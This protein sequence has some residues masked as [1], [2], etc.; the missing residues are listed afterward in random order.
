[1]HSHPILEV[2][3][4]RWMGDGRSR[5]NCKVVKVPQG[6]VL[7]IVLRKLKGLERTKLKKIKGAKNE[8]AGKYKGRKEWVVIGQGGDGESENASRSFP[9]G[10]M[11]KTLSFQCRKPKVPQPETKDPYAATK[12]SYATAK[13]STCHSKTWCIQINK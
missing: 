8:R 5:R 7:T 6:G 12:F 3:A 4:R 11:A 9:H 1:M 2:V 13:D 10:P